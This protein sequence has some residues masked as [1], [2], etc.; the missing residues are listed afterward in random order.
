[1]NYE[2]GI[3]LWVCVSGVLKRCGLL[4]RGRVYLVG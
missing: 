1:M 3:Y 2:Q 4:S